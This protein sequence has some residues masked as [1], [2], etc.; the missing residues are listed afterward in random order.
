MPLDAGGNKTPH[1]EYKIHAT[2]RP[3]QN[4]EKNGD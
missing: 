3:N 1:T 4:N 2:F